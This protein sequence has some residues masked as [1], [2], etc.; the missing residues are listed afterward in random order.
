[1]DPVE[2]PADPY[3]AYD[4]IP[5][6]YMP[7]ISAGPYTD[8]YCEYEVDPTWTV[9]RMQPGERLQSVFDRARP[10]GNP[11][12]VVEIP[13]EVTGENGFL[14]D[15]GRM[16]NNKAPDNAVIRGIP[17]PNGELP[18]F[19]CRN[20]SRDGNIPK[21]LKKR[22][23]FEISSK[24]LVVFENIRHDGYRG[25]PFNGYSGR[26]IFRNSWVHHSIGNGLVYSN[27]YAP[28]NPG[29]MVEVCGSE[30]SHNGAGNTEHGIYAHRG[31]VKEGATEEE[32]IAFVNNPS[33]VTFV[34]VDSYWHSN[35]YSSQIKSIANRNILKNNEIRSWAKDDPTFSNHYGSM[36]ID[37][38]A[39]SESTIEGNKI[40]HYKPK[41][42]GLGYYSLALR[43]RAKV[44]HGCDIPNDKHPDYFKKE[45][46]DAVEHTLVTTVRNNT[47]YSSPVF[48]GETLPEGAPDYSH[49]IVAITDWG[50]WPMEEV[51][52]GAQHWRMP[53]LDTA[54]NIIWKDQHRVKIEGNTFVGFTPGREWRA[55]VK[56]DCSGWRK[57]CP[58][59]VERTPMEYFGIEK[60]GEVD[61][62]WYFDIGENTFIPTSE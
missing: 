4:F 26:T 9:V 37:V 14:C 53:P 5:S 58:P 57:T 50:T 39:C 42:S 27:V 47:F 35:N 6:T 56:G 16:M 48:A 32:A 19:Q 34:S 43:N 31:T 24:G 52:L 12:V 46:W 59:P 54:G 55:L 49:K 13:Y 22:A 41:A 1:V 20:D 40:V 18:H 28:G 51:T 36:L 61:P 25:I 60:A 15:S 10:K 33:D 29:R 21:T 17:G 62:S 7:R 45:V 3:A 44:V 8:G 23:A 2:P 11:G 30:I 38:S